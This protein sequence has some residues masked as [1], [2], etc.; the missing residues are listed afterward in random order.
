MSSHVDGIVAMICCSTSGGKFVFLLE[1]VMADAKSDMSD[2]NGLYLGRLLD[3]FIVG[4]GCENP[5]LEPIVVM[6][7]VAA[8]LRRALA[9]GKKA[10]E[11]TV[12]DDRHNR[13][14]KAFWW[15]HIFFCK[16]GGN[17]F[18]SA[19]NFQLNVSRRLP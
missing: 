6:A 13:V 8:L 4:N 18:C 19:L 9:C 10:T 12:S 14:L 15:I 1:D 5:L 17:T 11:R 16:N 7:R 3:A 2:V